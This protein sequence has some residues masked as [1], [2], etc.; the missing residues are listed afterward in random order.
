MIDSTDVVLDDVDEPEDELDELDED[1]TWCNRPARYCVC[2][3][4]YER[5]KDEQ[6]GL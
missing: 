4:A 2:D 5:F 6:M 3:E 1:C